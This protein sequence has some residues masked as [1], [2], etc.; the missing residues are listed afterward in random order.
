LQS[1][2]AFALIERYISRHMCAKLSGVKL[3]LGKRDGFVD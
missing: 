3:T 2:D 1:L